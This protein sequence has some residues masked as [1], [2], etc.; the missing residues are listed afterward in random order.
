MSDSTNYGGGF[1]TSL[2]DIL[3]NK[4][5]EARKAMLD[6]INRKNI[7]SEIAARAD[8]A[9]TNKLY[10]AAEASKMKAEEGDRF[11]KH[12][13]KDQEVSPETY[14]KA[15]GYD[16]QDM[17]TAPIPGMG[18]EFQGPMPEGQ[19]PAATPGK[20]RGSPEEIEADDRRTQLNAWLDGPEGQ[21][22]RQNEPDVWAAYKAQ[23]ASEKFGV[24]IPAGAYKKNDPSKGPSAILLPDNTFMYN[25]AKVR[26]VPAGTPIVRGFAPPR[27]SSSSEGTA[28]I[29]Q[30]PDPNNPGQFISV[31]A[32]GKAKSIEPVVLPPELQPKP[33]VVTPPSQKLPSGDIQLFPPQ[34][35][36]A[37]GPQVF[38]RT[39]PPKPVTEKGITSQEITGIRNAFEQTR[40]NL[41]SGASTGQSRQIMYTPLHVAQMSIIAKLPEQWMKDDVISAVQAAEAVDYNSGK[42]PFGT[43]QNFI[44]N[45]VDPQGNPLNESQKSDLYRILSYVLGNF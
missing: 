45:E 1:G 16:L 8:Q 25:G 26:S 28:N 6:E 37:P 13:H 9:E 32:N 7:E 11:L 31:W 43:I 18:P 17:F 33:T 42:Y 40:K 30:I 35:K 4:R 36:A 34:E 22:L 44:E 20:F 3:L 12:F 19:T 21:Q 10:R 39:A 41:K 15:K 5:E 24:S 29:Q 14:D 38:S 2:Y 27:P 23:A